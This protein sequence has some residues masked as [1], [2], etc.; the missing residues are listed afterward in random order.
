M[1]PE[2][3]L[4]CTVPGDP[5]APVVPTRTP[6]PK[7][8]TH[9]SFGLYG[10]KNTRSGWRNESLDTCANVGV[11]DRIVFEYHSPAVSVVTNASLVLSSPPSWNAFAELMFCPAGL[12]SAGATQSACQPAPPS[13]VRWA[14][15]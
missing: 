2:P 14:N 4:S 15:P 7:P 8:I 10:L 9:I 13:V 12:R 6:L 3:F 5:D 1:L 11:A